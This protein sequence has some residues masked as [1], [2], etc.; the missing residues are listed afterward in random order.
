MICNTETMVSQ[1]SG[2]TVT[3]YHMEERS[4]SQNNAA[5]FNHNT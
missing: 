4:K 1:S 2:T 5:L 3:I